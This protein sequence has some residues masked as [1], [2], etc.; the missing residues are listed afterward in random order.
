MQTKLIRIILLLSV[1]PCLFAQQPSSNGSISSS[2]PRLGTPGK[3][4]NFRRPYADDR[5]NY[6]VWDKSFVVAF[7]HLSSST[8][9]SAALYND[10][11]EVLFRAL[12]WFPDATDV[13]IKSAAATDQGKLIV[14]G[15]SVS[16]DGAIADFIAEV[17]ERGIVRALR[18]TPHVPDLICVS[19]NL[20]W[21]YGWNRRSDE[22]FDNLLAA[23]DLTKGL[24]YS[25]L[26]RKSVTLPPD[27]TILGSYPGQVALRCNDQGASLMLAPAMELVTVDSASKRMIRRTFK[28][29]SPDAKI[30][31]SALTSKGDFLISVRM[32]NRDRG[33]GLFHLD[34][35]NA[36][37][38]WVAVEGTLGSASD[39]DLGFWSLEGSHGEEIVYFKR[40]YPDRT[41]SRASIELRKKH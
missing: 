33:I 7:N 23:Y 37:P 24:I 1:L 12:V 27:T 9:E 5:W 35:D 16:K 11:G 17:A 28:G 32:L 15:S 19:G 3:S 22:S 39:K 34:N 26:D 21:T 36:T 20:V 10:E 30:T 38:T 40:P 31:G 41:L 18:T 29:L 13:R 6:R 14:A 4:A 25:G 8:A 2:P